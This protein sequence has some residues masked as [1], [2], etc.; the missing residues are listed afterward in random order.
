VC[1]KGG[2]PAEF[3]KVFGQPDV[4]FLDSRR[5]SPEAELKWTEIGGNTLPPQPGHPD[6]GNA[7]VWRATLRNLTAGGECL[8]WVLRRIGS[9]LSVDLELVA[10]EKLRDRLA[11]SDGSPVEIN[12]EGSWIHT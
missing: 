8:C 11:L 3:L 1:V 7:Q 5:F 4:R 6:R 10:G 9:G 12:L 2:F